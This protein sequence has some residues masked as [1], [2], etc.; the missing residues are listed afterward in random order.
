MRNTYIF[1][2]KLE[3]KRPHGDIGVGGKIIL[4]WT[5]TESGYKFEPFG[6]VQCL[7]RTPVTWLST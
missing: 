4:T 5:P 1:A 3:G 2:G 7:K 6:S